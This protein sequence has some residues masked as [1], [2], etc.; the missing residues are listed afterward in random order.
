ML[1]FGRGLPN[2]RGFFCLIKEPNLLEKDDKNNEEAEDAE[3]DPQYEPI[4]SLP[5]VEVPTLE[6]DETELLNL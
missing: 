5:E 4:I 6:E 3:H 2:Y 1:W